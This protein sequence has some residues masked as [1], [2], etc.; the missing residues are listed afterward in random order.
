[1]QLNSDSNRPVARCIAYQ[2][3]CTY[4]PRKL[5][6]PAVHPCRS[7][8]PAVCRPESITHLLSLLPS[9]CR[10]SHA[11]RT[12]KR[13]HDNSHEVE[14]TLSSR[15]FGAHALRLVPEILVLRCNCARW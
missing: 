2:T 11:R 10:T 14:G 7:P 9:S 6:R 4:P 5:R 8:R 13:A 3:G 1:M 12:G 15:C